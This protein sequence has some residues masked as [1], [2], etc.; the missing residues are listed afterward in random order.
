MPLGMCHSGVGD[1]KTASEPS[2]LHVCNLTCF[3]AQS[4]LYM[5]MLVL[6]IVKILQYPL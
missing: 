5:A 3:Y 4:V 6:I 1:W 2:G